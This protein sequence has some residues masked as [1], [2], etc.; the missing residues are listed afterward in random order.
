MG[1]LHVP[2]LY[3]SVMPSYYDIMQGL[4]CNGLFVV[5]VNSH[6]DVVVVWNRI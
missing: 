6:F 4:Q 5:D 2:S 1:Q 3:C